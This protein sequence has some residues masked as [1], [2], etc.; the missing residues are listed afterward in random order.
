MV[1]FPQKPCESLFS[2]SKNLVMFMI[3]LFLIL[4]R[5][6]CWWVYGDVISCWIHISSQ[7][8]SSSLEFRFCLFF[9]HQF[10]LVENLKHFIFAFICIDSHH[11]IKI[12]HKENKLYMRVCV[13][14]PFQWH[15]VKGTTNISMYPIKFSLSSY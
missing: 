14:V 9:C 15:C 5:T 4:V 12:L 10:K 6:L 3:V 7:K 13:Y 2:F 11:Y 8:I 1:A